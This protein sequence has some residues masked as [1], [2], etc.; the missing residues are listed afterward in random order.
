MFYG[1]HA[2]KERPVGLLCSVNKL[3]EEGMSPSKI[4]HFGGGAFLLVL[5]S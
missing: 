2:V 5:A 4:S 3:C 1:I